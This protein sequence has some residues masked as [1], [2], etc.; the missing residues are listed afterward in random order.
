[1]SQEDY[2]KGID[3]CRKEELLRLQKEGNLTWTGKCHECPHC[4]KAAVEYKLW[5]SA[6]IWE[7]H[8]FCSSCGFD[9]WTKQVD[10]FNFDLNVLGGV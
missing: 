7:D 2:S 4:Y 8:F 5:N 3:V 10:D 1:M 6:G 9:S